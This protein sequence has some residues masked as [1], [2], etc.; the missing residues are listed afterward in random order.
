[1]C[2]YDYMDGY[3]IYILIAPFLFW[4]F[5]VDAFFEDLDLFSQVVIAAVLLFISLVL[6]YG[7]DGTMEIFFGPPPPAPF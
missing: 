4:L 3:I 2:N 6:L 5:M 7:W 1:M